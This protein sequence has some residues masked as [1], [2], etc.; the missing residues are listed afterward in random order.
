MQSQVKTIH[1]VKLIEDD[2]SVVLSHNRHGCF[3]DDSIRFMLHSL[4]P[5]TA[6]IDV[7]AYT[8]LYSLVASRYCDKVYAYEPIRETYFRFMQNIKLNGYHNI[9]G[10]NSAIYDTTELH[11]DIHFTNN[12]KFNSA[13][14][15]EPRKQST[16]T[17]TVNI[18]NRVLILD[19]VSCIKIDAER[20]ELNV[21]KVLE[22]IIKRDKPNMIIETLTDADEITI[23]R[24]LSKFNYSF[25]IMDK[26]NL[27]CF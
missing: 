24:F 8:G 2:D 5:D 18:T 25:Q 11:K 21:L 12:S 14:T 19:T 15:F 23:M 22:P 7:G 9:I 1:S 26:R 13:A 27:I 10:R 16:K 4:S 6:F 17:E 20:S 3:E